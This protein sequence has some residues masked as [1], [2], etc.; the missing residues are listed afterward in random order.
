LHL[1]GYL[2]RCSNDARSHELQIAKNCLIRHVCLSVCLSARNNS[3]SYREFY[4]IFRIEKCVKS[5]QKFGLR[6]NS[7]K[8]DRHFTCRTTDIVSSVV[9]FVTIVRKVT[10]VSNLSM[11][12]FVTMVPICAI[13][14][15][16]FLLP[17]ATFITNLT[18]VP[19]F[20]WLCELAELSYCIAISRLIACRGD[21]EGKQDK[22]V[23]GMF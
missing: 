4:F 15:V 19:K 23:I 3:T 7:D 5:V 12:T 9:T 10:S 2:H 18:K 13:L 20:L 8:N 17:L 16:Y 21:S 22:W 11:V 14:T 6:L 1:V